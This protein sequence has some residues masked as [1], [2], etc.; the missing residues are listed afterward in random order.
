[1][2]AKCS[3]S[4][5]AVAMTVG[6]LSSVAA[7]AATR[8]SPYRGPTAQ[9]PHMNF[10]VNS[11]KVTAIAWGEIVTCT[12]SPTANYIDGPFHARVDASGRFTLTYRGSGV[13][14]VSGR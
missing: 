3:A 7:P 9:G 13:I 12:T 4:L 14:K 11:A 8:G 1:M 2:N 6:L 10:R 5:V